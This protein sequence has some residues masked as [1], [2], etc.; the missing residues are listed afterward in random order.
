MIETLINKIVGSLS[1]KKTISMIVL[2]LGL[3]LQGLIACV[4]IFIFVNFVMEAMASWWLPVWPYIIDIINDHFPSVIQ[5]FGLSEPVIELLTTIVL[6]VGLVL[7]GFL[8]IC[9][10]GVSLGFIYKYFKKSIRNYVECNKFIATYIYSLSR[11][12][13]LNANRSANLSKLDIPHI[14]K[15]NFDLISNEGQLKFNDHYYLSPASFS[16]LLNSASTERK[17]LLFSEA[18]KLSNE[19]KAAQNVIDNINSCPSSGLMLLS[20]F[21]GAPFALFLIW[22]IFQRLVAFF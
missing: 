2:F 18:K 21:F 20:I 13:W 1:P 22:S 14:N 5:R 9:V 19:C 4:A 10:M 3:S 8:T 7:F 16:E 12:I 15:K 11:L 17:E 6:L